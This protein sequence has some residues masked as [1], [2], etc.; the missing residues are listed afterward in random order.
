[1]DRR[2]RQLR[3]IGDGAWAVEVGDIVSTFQR[4]DVWRL[5]ALTRETVELWECQEPHDWRCC[6][7]QQHGGTCRRVGTALIVG[8]VEEALWE[9]P[10][11]LWA[12]HHTLGDMH[13]VLEE[14]RYAHGPENATPGAIYIALILHTVEVTEWASGD[15][16]RRR[17]T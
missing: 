17:T 12:I 4:A 1:M 5:P 8:W 2:L 15:G 3:A 11:H 16:T 7:P 14:L 6:T 9:M 10:S 13:E